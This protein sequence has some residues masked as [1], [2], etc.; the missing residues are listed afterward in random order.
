M[1]K[2]DMAV[3]YLTEHPDEIY[4]AWGNPFLHKGGCLFQFC[5]ANGYNAIICGCLTQIRRGGY[6]AETE[7]LTEEIRNDERIPSSALDIR[8]EHLPV[9]AEWQRRLDKELRG[10]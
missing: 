1:D 3:E 4:D 10:R 7:E 6:A 2:Y 8:A 5:N 9:F